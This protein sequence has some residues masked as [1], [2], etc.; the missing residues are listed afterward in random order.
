MV[1]PTATPSDVRDIIDTDVETGVI[2]SHL[3]DAAW[4][5]ADAN[6]TSTLS[7]EAIR[8]AEKYLAALHLREWYDRAIA[9]ADRQSASLRFEGPS[10]AALRRAVDK[11][12]PSGS[13][14][15][16]RDTDRHVTST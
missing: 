15:H 8:Q 13:L 12:D 14:A 3:A 9:E 1:T 2:E 11:R 4:E 16:Q 6:D 7:T 5:F 10:T